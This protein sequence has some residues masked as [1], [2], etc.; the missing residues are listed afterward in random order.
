MSVANAGVAISGGAATGFVGE[1]HDTRRG[2]VQLE[3]DPAA[4]EEE[5]PIAPDQFDPRYES[6]KWEIWAYY[7]YYIGR[8]P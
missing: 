6:S 1:D 5:H 3:D 7:C 2:S 8:T 4:L